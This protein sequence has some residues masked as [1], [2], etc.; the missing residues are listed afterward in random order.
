MRQ[1]SAARPSCA[2]LRVMFHLGVRC[3]FG[4]LVFALLVSCGGRAKESG[5]GDVGA[6]DDAMSSA[7]KSSRAK[8][9]ASGTGAAGVTGTAGQGGLEA[10]N[11]A[12][13]C[14]TVGAGGAPNGNAGET[15]RGGAGAFAHG[16][17]GGVSAGGTASDGGAAAGGAS[18][19]DRRA[20][21]TAACASLCKELDVCGDGGGLG[22]DCAPDCEA[23]LTARNGECVELGLPMAA[24]LQNARS[25]NSDCIES[26][27]RAA[28]IQCG[29][30]V[31]AYQDC[32]AGT[33]AKELPPMLC[34]RISGADSESCVEDR[35]CLNSTWYNLKCSAT[36][37]GPSDCTCK[38]HGDF[39]EDVTLTETLNEGT[40]QACKRQIGACL[41]AAAS[42]GG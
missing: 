8:P 4:L 29:K 21:V 5:V 1:S 19:G 18:T 3:A 28:Q 2:T 9:A 42:N 34:A 37:D 30:Q 23:T 36:S 32:V 16:D 15:A 20:E 39:I 22:P 25:F 13:G 17:G 6:G 14:S 7:G 33:G 41:A 12:G 40:A 27:F 11:G 24:C 10:G 38:V 26:F 35:K 31:T